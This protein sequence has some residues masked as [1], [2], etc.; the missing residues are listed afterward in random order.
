MFRTVMEMVSA[1]RRKRRF[2][3]KEPFF[4]RDIFLENIVLQRAVQ[5]LK[6]DTALS[7]TA[8]YIAKIT[9]AGPLI[10]IDA[11][12]IERNTAESRSILKDEIATPQ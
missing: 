3:R 6:T 1:I 12:L 11:D 7:A 5:L 8:R 10:V 9:A 4:L 2:W